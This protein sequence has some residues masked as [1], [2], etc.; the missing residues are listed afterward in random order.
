MDELTNIASG[1]MFE[2]TVF[3]GGTSTSTENRVPFQHFD[4]VPGIG[5]VL[6]SAKLQY[7]PVF[8]C[9]A[10]KYKA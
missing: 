10:I 3:Q 8:C 5:H 7:L 9:Q 6:V 4:D 1:T 2:L